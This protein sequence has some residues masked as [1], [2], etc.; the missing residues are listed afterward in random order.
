[1]FVCYFVQCEIAGHVA[2]NHRQ[3]CAS[4]FSGW[5]GLQRRHLQMKEVPFDLFEI[6]I[7]KMKLSCFDLI[8]HLFIFAIYVHILLSTR[9]SWLISIVPYIHTQKPQFCHWRQLF[10][11]KNTDISTVDKWK[12]WRYL[13]DVYNRVSCYDYTYFFSTL[14]SDIYIPLVVCDKET[15][16]KICT[17]LRFW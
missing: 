1:M 16:K 5:A 4:L 3:I 12:L 2:T 15:T 11:L 6:T 14:L 13:S 8:T 17:Q 10:K 9:S 7:Q